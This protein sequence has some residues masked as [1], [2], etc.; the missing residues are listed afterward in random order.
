MA[1]RRGLMRVVGKR[2]DRRGLWWFLLLLGAAVVVCGYLMATHYYG[3]VETKSLASLAFWGML[4]GGTLT[5]YAAMELIQPAVQ[6]S[7]ARLF[8]GIVRRSR[9]R[10]AAAQNENLD[11]RDVS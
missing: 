4:A 1:E 11:R 5:L 10:H 8:A 3:D 7:L 2:R 6:R 9:D